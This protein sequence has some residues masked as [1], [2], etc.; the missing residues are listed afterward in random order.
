MTPNEEQVRAA[1][2]EQ[3]TNWLIAH[4]DRLMDAQQSAA[5]AAWLRVSPVHVEEFLRVSAIARD[6]RDAR[7]A[8]AYSLEHV[9]ADAR[10][11]NDTLV[12]PL[13]PRTIAP[14]RAMFGP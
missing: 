5:L 12:G 3:A 14:V 8:P 10:T 7:S 2:A 4:N 11:E 1:I 6:L 9:L 13:W